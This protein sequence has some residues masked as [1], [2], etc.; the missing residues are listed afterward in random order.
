MA[1]IKDL[2]GRI[3][4]MLTVVKMAEHKLCERVKWVCICSCGNTTVVNGSSLKN[5]HTKSC[6]CL[7]R[8]SF[9]KR[10]TS[11]GMCYSPENAAYRKMKLRCNNENNPRYRDYGGRGIKICDRWLESFDNFYEDMGKRPSKK[12]SLD[13]IDNAVG[14]SPN[15]CRWSTDIE[16]AN[17]KRNNLRLTLGSIT[18]TLANWSRITEINYGTLRSRIV[19]S[20]WSVKKALTTEVRA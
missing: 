8:A 5:G 18:D 10:S 15:N 14:Y 3:F 11:H 7:S 2:T 19:D 13:R 12:H 20:G 6:G 17:N 9:I 16:Q 4:N 1:K